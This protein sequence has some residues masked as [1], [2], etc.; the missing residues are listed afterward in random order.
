M[1]IVKGL[2]ITPDEAIKLDLCPETGRP[3]AEVN[4]EEHVNALWPRPSAMSAE[5]AR[6]RELILEWHAAHP[7][8]AQEKA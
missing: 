6:R 1:P 4:P 5:G 2:D 3:L 7:K 8:P